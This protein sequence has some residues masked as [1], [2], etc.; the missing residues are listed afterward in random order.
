[1]DPLTISGF[2][3]LFQGRTDAYG[4]DRG[5]VMREKPDEEW[6]SYLR[7]IAMH[8]EDNACSIGVYPWVHGQVH[9]GCVDFDGH[10]D[11]DVFAHARNVQALLRQCNVASF[12]ERTRSGEGYHVW[13]FA[14]DW[15]DAPLMRRALLGACQVVDAPLKEI[16]PKS[17]T[18]EPDQL[19][20]YV[21]L[22]YPQG[23][24]DRCTQVMVTEHN[25]MIP[26][27]TFVEAALPLRVNEDGLNEVAA[28]YQEPV[29]PVIERTVQRPRTGTRGPES[30]LSSLAYV[31]WRDGPQK[32]GRSEGLH[33][34]SCLMAE[35][36]KLSWGEAMDL[37]I[38]A[39]QRWGKFMARPNG[40]KTLR[41][42]LAK[43]W[44]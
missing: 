25:V 33:L 12:V 1:M 6:P 7:A 11:G 28:L 18:L 10:R 32:G 23:W 4:T 22:P 34:L 35:E 8:L 29:R 36:G 17:W 19:G 40:E 24:D 38:D 13:L 20:N 37:L 14:Q 30:E 39:D 44:R 15:V 16:N 27:E 43:V 21:R 41:D 31:L 2:A 9:W 5:G 3:E 26:L 42:G